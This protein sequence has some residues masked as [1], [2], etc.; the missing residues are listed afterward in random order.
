MFHLLIK[1]GLFIIVVFITI[2]TKAQSVKLDSLV[3]N[4]DTIT[5]D[6]IKATKVTFDT[7][8]SYYAF[9]TKQQIPKRA[10]M[11][12]ALLPGLGQ[13]Y[14]KQTWKTSIVY[15]GFGVSTYFIIANKTLYDDYR[16]AIVARLD[17][18]PNTND[19]KYSAYSVPI[20][21]DLQR[22]HRSALDKV[23][24]FTSLWYG[25]NIIDAL[26]AA[27]LKDFSMSKNLSYQQ[28]QPLINNNGLG[29]AILINNK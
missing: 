12:S 17:N 23:G 9:K 28:I 10:A 6:T 20:L 2:T 25:I 27:H 4:K 5:K 26:V 19:T 8:K 22:K 13:V 11:Y 21:K 24:V 1:Y 18:D 7:T 3:L 29:L 16:T 14:N 15:A